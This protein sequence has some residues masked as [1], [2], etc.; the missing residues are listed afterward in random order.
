[1]A[2]RT[3]KVALQ[4]QVSGFVAGMK[5]ANKAAGDF[6]KNL[7]DAA[8]KNSQHLNQLSGSLGLMGAGLVGFAALAVKS[9][10]DFDKAMSHVQAATHA[11]AGDMKLLRD[12]ALEAGQR[13]AY[14]ATEAAGAIEE[15]SKAGVSTADVLG[16]GLDGALDLAAAGS[17]DVKDAAEVAATA[18][19]QFGLSGD[20]IPHVADLLAAAAGK[21]QGEVSDM[22]AA[23]KQGGLVAAQMGWSIEETTATLASFAAAGLLGS[24]AGTSLKTMLLQLVN[25]SAEAAETMR[26]L[27]ISAYDVQ[28]NFVGAGNLAGQ[29][30]E[31]MKDLDPA[32]RNAALATI[33]GSDAIRAA[34]IMYKNGADGVAEWTDKV[35]DQGYATETAA[36]KMDNL[37]GDLEKLSG[38]FDNALIGLGE[39]ADGPL[40]SLTQKLTEAVDGFNNLDPAVK[41][42]TLAIIGGGGLAIL[43]VAGVL[44]LVTALGEAKVA[45]QALGVTA[46]KT[47]TVLKFVG[48]VGAIGGIVVAA[49]WLSDRLGN[50]NVNAEQL[51]KNLETWAGKGAAS[52]EVARLLG[53]D[54]VWLE[55]GITRLA[56]PSKFESITNALDH[57]T[58]PGWSWGIEDTEKRF[59]QLD[60]ALSTLVA[61]GKAD[62]AAA[63]MTRF[64][65]IAESKGVSVDKL[66]KLFPQY[67][68]ALADS[69]KPADDAAAGTR[70]VGEAADAAKPPVDEISEALKNME[71]RA[72]GLD[73][74][75]KVL[76]STLDN[77]DAEAAYEGAI[78]DLEAR[79]KEYREE[80]KKGD[81]ATKHMSGV[82]D[83]TTKAGRDNAAA[84]RELWRNSSDYAVQTL[85]TT[86][87][88]KA[89]NA[90]LA[91]GREELVRNAAAF[92]GS[93]K[94]GDAAWVAADRY[95]TEVLG[96]PK[97]INSQWKTPG[98]SPALANARGLNREAD[99]ADGRKVTVTFTTRRNN[100]VE[101]R[102]RTLPWFGQPA[103]G[104]LVGRYQPL[105]PMAGGGHVQGPGSWTSDT[106]GLFALSNNEFVMRAAAVSRFGVDFFDRLN[107]GSLDL[108]AI[109]R[110]GKRP[111][112]TAGVFASAGSHT[113]R[114]GD[115]TV[116]VNARSVDLN[117]RTL[118]SVTHAAR[119]RARV[120]RPR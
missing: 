14:S 95:V 55:E 17:I 48:V 22:A 80:V 117:E 47:A 77:L 67:N 65:D 96:V 97:D 94:A 38:S 87:N 21:A 61:N 54:F 32:T 111:V 59:K 29:L 13:T 53:D 116:N 62:E 79:L 52:G 114:E 63:A 25:P 46:G 40:R 81:E 23:L 39:G 89:A 100:Y 119:L 44:K 15:L 92:M 4:A 68:K 24:D 60:E 66:A 113:A 104:G 35:W 110:G 5:T 12:A 50:V 33:F 70:G 71:T 28:G 120:G 34:S 16:G 2:N 88:Q 106:A 10:A 51:T 105:I 45:A 107:Q 49:D 72:K 86:G 74:A 19:T 42:A 37:A 82:F 101:T 27:G 11:S 31:H 84:M 1:V 118:Q 99:R 56:D 30:S 75:M 91:K 109:K 103:K 6:S 8:D 43:G 20:K 78:D 64:G 112:Q 73:E 115:V 102:E 98:L 76:N 90:I 108:G 93:K 26:N 41:S 18:M 58:T 36:I 83:L 7:L 57:W 9:F 85:E 3:V 69:K